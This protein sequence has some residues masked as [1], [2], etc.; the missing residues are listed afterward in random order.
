MFSKTYPAT[1]ILF[2]DA[3]DFSGDP[4]PQ[5]R[6]Q[7][8]AV[9]D[10]MNAMAYKVSNLSLR[11]L[12]DGY[13]TFLQRQK[14][15][16]FAFVSANIVWQATGEPIAAPTTVVRTT[17]RDGAKTKEVR[18]GF[19]GLTRHDPAFHKEAEGGRSIVTID[20]L[21]AVEKRVPALKQKAD[22]IVALVAMDLEQARLIPKKAREI[23]LVLGG[24]SNPGK[25]AV[26][27]RTDDFPEDTQ[28]GRA[29]LLYAADQGKILGE[30]RLFFD[31]K[32]TITSTQRSL[33]SLTRDWPDDP[34]LA[35]IQE[36][37][38]VAIN[39]YNKTQTMG[40]SPFAP[41]APAATPAP[42]SSAR[43][44]SL[45]SPAPRTSAG[46]ISIH[47]AL[48]QP[49]TY[50]GSDRCAPCHEQAFAKWATSGHAH[51]FQTLI[52][53]KQEYHPKCL[54]CHTIGYGMTHGYISPIAT[55]L[56]VNVG[57]E[58]CHGPSSR[59][60][61]QVQQGFGRTNTEFCVSCHSSE[62]SPDFK[63][64]EY[65]PKVKHWDDQHAQR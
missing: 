34:V 61:D 20:P 50:T 31:N 23:D 17:L 11:D 64:A 57:C 13:D 29:R 39:E 7:T 53:N 26:Q 48:A 10:G 45:A 37:V 18:I 59:H 9:I 63:P 2:V 16:R 54:G 58:S 38:K 4:T 1:P 33:I 49:L 35:K 12:E 6:M 15:A 40:Q 19:I 24:D 46:P 44:P 30:V 47:E 5:G 3:G 62:N 21:A 51:A 52:E 8:D 41:A 56:L 65:I 36:T 55:P 60:P 42:G 22:I 27:T 28:F 43:A 14:R 25:T 32:K